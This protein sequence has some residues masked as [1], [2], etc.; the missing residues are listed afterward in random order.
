MTR[1]ALPAS[2]ALAFILGNL[3]VLST[4]ARAAL[5]LAS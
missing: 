3:P 4:T 2:K 1:T 5:A